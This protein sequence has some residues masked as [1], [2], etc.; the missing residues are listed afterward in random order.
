MPASADSTRAPT[1]RYP[2]AM[3]RRRLL[4][5]AIA[6]L[7]AGGLWWFG[8]GDAQ[9]T[10]PAATWRLGTGTDVKQGQNYDEL[11]AETP[12]RLAFGCEE[13]RHVYVFSHSRQDGTVLLFPSEDLRSDLAQPLPAGRPVLPGKRDGRELAWTTRSQILPLTTFVAIASREPLPEL[14]ALL[15]RLRRWSTSVLA[16]GSMQVTKPGTTSGTE[17]LGKP[18]EPLP[19]PLLQ[20]AADAFASETLI[21]GP[22]RPLAGHDGVWCTAWR[23]KEKPGSAKAFDPQ[24]PVLPEALRPLQANPSPPDKR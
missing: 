13:P 6:L 22:M 3:D 19:S 10:I 12:V 2:F 23:V 20:A 9:R 16:D 4:V 17:V 11:P 21:N 5:P 24:N 1:A 14:D 18:G 7:V 8:R 15:P